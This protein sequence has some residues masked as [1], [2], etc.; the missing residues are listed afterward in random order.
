[1]E[2]FVLGLDVPRRIAAEKVLEGPEIDDRL[3]RIN[4]RRI[5][6]GVAREVLPAIKV[7]M[8][9]NVRLPRIFHGRLEGH[10]EHTL[11]A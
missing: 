11:G 5:A 2:P 1:V 10:Y 8:G 7:H 3:P 6:V 4:R 9:L